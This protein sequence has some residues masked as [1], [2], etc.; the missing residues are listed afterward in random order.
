MTLARSFLH[1]R[2]LQVIP[3]ENEMGA[4]GVTLVIAE[5]SSI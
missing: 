1:S 2:W 3:L 4:S 5:L